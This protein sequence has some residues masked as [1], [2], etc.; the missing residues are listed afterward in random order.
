MNRKNVFDKLKIA[1]Q[2]ELILFCA[3]IGAF[4]GAVVWVLLKIMAVGME[5][6]WQ[7]IP[8]HIIFPFYTIALCTIGAAIIGVFRKKYGDYPEELD[9][10]MRKVKTEKHY[11]YKNMFVMMIAALLPLLMGSSVGPEAGLTGI[12]VGLCYWAGDNL[13][14]A[15]QQTKEYSQVGV[16]VSL[17]ILFHSPLFGIFQ[18][19]EDSDEPISKLSKGSKL[20]VYGVALTCATGI[21]AGLSALF[22]AGLSGFPSFEMEK[23]ERMDYVLIIVYML[24][25]L[26]LSGFYKGTHYITKFVAAKVPSVLREIIA[27]GCL[28]VIGTFVPATLFSGEEQM[29]V[30]IANYG[31]YL[32][33]TLI[34]IAFLKIFLTNLCIQFGLKGGHFFPVI[35]AGVCMGYGVA[36]FIFGTTGGHVVFAAAI[37][38]ATLL[39]GIMKKPIAVTMLLFL[40]FPIKLF[41]WIF[42]AA[43]VGTETAKIKK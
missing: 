38:T 1:N 26:I 12:I 10:V 27:G 23:I 3:L 36:V 32:P 43:V 11:E 33:I 7:W 15:K 29:G 17:S 9:A 35:F 41:I 28:G 42:I 40:C 25:G 6:L 5:I 2:L 16:A 30:L 21:Y 4:A 19:E 31:Q 14:F 8:N 13:M 22:G 34:G 24:C 18:V 20:L 39:G 37:V